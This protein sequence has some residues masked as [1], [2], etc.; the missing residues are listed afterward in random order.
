E[1][2]QGAAPVDPRLA[3]LLSEAFRHAKAIGGW[4][5]AESVLNASSV[6]ADAPGVV[7]ADSGEA[8]LSGLT[9]LLAKHRVWDRFPPAL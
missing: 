8:V 4:A 6:P 5:G 3:L 9:P 2:G 1:P 7:L